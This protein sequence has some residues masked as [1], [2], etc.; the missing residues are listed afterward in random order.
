MAFNQ[1][2]V[3]AGTAI[4]WA[5]EAEAGVR[6]TTGYKLIPNVKSISGFS[7]EPNML[8]TTDLSEPDSHTYVRGLKDKSDA[9]SLG[10]NLNQYLITAWNALYQAYQEALAAG[11]GMWFAITFPNGFEDA[12]YFRGE[13]VALG[14]SDIDVDSPLETE[15]KIVP[16]KVEGFA[17]KPTADAA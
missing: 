15:A 6:P 3:S 12:Y 16:Q 10:M 13:P 1:A 17:A 5:V 7:E 8:Q 14:F 2:V 9:V 11:K 4:K